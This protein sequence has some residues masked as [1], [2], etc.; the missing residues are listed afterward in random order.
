MYA[1]HNY[2]VIDVVTVAILNNLINSL[3]ILFFK[4]LYIEIIEHVLRCSSD[5]QYVINLNVVFKVKQL[6]TAVV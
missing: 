1:L 5:Y 3:L 2:T 6:N 4:I